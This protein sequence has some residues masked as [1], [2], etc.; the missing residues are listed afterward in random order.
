[1]PTSHGDQRRSIRPILLVEADLACRE[2]LYDLLTRHGCSVIAVHSGERAMGVLKHERPGVILADA[3]LS[4]PT[5]GDLVDRIR[6]FDANLPIILLGTAREANSDT[7]MAGKV[8]GYFPNDVP[9]H[10]L[11]QEV[12]RWLNA[13]EP[14][15]TERW[16][17][18]ILVVDDEPKLRRILEE[19]LQLHGF[20]VMTATSGEDALEKLQRW[21]P[22]VVLLDVKMPGMDG[23]IVL[24]KIKALRPGVVVIMMTGLEEEQLLGQ[25]L[26]LGA[27][28]YLMKPF[29]L[30]Y[31]ESTL[32]S[33]LLLGNTPP[34]P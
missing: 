17:G 13:P 22:T 26:A 14:A 11:L 30:A 29:D 6:S 19:F 27:Y 5:G 9:D 2:R 21:L 7:V 32:L 34:P 10:A 8:Q 33:R 1:M 12:D 24:K 23:L 4:D 25:A 15:R 31:L 3:A 28:D 16:P 18:S 20:T